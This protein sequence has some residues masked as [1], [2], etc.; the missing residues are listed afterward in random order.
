MGVIVNKTLKVPSINSKF[1]SVKLN[2]GYGIGS[3][4]TSKIDGELMQ[5]TLPNK[6][7]NFNGKNHLFSGWTNDKNDLK[8]KKYAPGLTLDVLTDS[9][10]YAVW[11]DE[12]LYTVRY[13]FLGDSGTIKEF[14]EA[15]NSHTVISDIPTFSAYNFVGWSLKPNDKRN[16]LTAGN[17]LTL[18]GY[19]TMLYAVYNDPIP[20]DGL[21]VTLKSGL[22]NG[23]D[24]V[25]YADESGNVTLPKSDEIPSGWTFTEEYEGFE[26]FGWSQ[27]YDWSNDVTEDEIRVKAGETI[28]IT[29]NVILF[30]NL[31]NPEKDC[32]IYFHPYDASRQISLEGTTDTISGLPAKVEDQI[33]PY[34]VIGYYPTKVWQFEGYDF[35]GWL[36]G[37]DDTE[38]VMNGNLGVLTHDIHLY[39]CY[40]KN[41]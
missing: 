19:S 26:L 16:L 17:E 31:S 3:V 35:I 39:S 18:N 22:M 23:N 5:Y 9:T 28:N 40:V 25:I 6:P 27:H 7:A 29:K 2:P 34:G 11:E 14:T 30:P 21:K 32:T 1:I 24:V 41:S 13:F 8:N 33:Y 38:P 15:E 37:K 4:L 12:S 20:V 10:F 36:I